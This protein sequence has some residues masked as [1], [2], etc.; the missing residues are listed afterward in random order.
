MTVQR[1]REFQTFV[2][3]RNRLNVQLDRLRADIDRWLEVNGQGEV[4][5]LADIAKLAGLLETRKDLLT[6]LA[7][8][9]ED[10]LKY[11]LHLRS[12]Q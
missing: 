11:L 7:K 9:D 2:D 6:E 12:L 3:G 1:D 10:F 4:R 5:S 8:L